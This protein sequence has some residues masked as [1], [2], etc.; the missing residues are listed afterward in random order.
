MSNFMN[1]LTTIFSS[2]HIVRAAGLTA[3]F[4]LFLTTAGGL[5]LSL[6]A[7]PAKYR[8]SMTN[9]HNT[10]ALTGLLFTLLHLSAL[11]FDKEIHFSLADVLIPFWSSYQPLSS[12]LGI[13]AF[14]VMVI[15]TLTS[16]P[17]LIKRLGFRAWKSIHYLAFL[18]YPI[19]LSHSVA[20]GTDS[21]D[22]FVSTLYI[23][24]GL[25]VV[26]LIMLRVKKSMQGRG[27]QY[28]YSPRGR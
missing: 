26:S 16:I 10:V 17:V 12:T 23:G 7:V 14:Y 8:S 9:I 21:G 3:Y 20:L 11:L 25:I 4:L 13:I 24:T 22:T 5:L 15:M 28:A 1:E 27:S 19:A 18:C 2:W 6:Q